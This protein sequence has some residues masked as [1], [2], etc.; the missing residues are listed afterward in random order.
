MLNDLIT[1]WSVINFNKRQCSYL[2]SQSL[3][4]EGILFLP[5][6]HGLQKVRKKCIPVF[7][8]LIVY[9]GNVGNMQ[10]KSNS[11]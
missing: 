5:Q 6:Y 7:I 8:N 11:I 4:A 1:K 10:V 2:S 3:S 9:S